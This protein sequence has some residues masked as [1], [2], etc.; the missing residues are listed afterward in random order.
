MR[1]GFAFTRSGFAFMRSHFAFTRSGFAFMRSGFAFMRSGFV[2]MRCDN[3]LIPFVY[4]FSGLRI[5][6]WLCR[7]R[8]QPIAPA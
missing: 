3:A 6:R 4:V 7:D 8:T 1:S 2:F 5:K